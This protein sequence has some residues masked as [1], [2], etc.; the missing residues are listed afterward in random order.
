MIKS[1]KSGGRGGDVDVTVAEYLS[2]VSC[3][4]MYTTR[5]IN[6]CVGLK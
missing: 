6:G 2:R 4:G 3:G 5:D 1:G